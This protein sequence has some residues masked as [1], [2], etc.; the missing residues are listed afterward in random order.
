[1]YTFTS[2]KFTETVEMDDT[3]IPFGTTA[4]VTLDF[5]FSNIQVNGKGK[6][7]DVKHHWPFNNKRAREYE[8]ELLN[9]TGVME[10]NIGGLLFKEGQLIYLDMACVITHL[11]AVV[12]VKIDP[13]FRIYGSISIDEFNDLEKEIKRFKNTLDIDNDLLHEHDRLLKVTYKNRDSVLV[14]ILP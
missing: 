4:F 5:G 8:L 1:M 13:E 12:N 11:P 3:K 2:I 6:I 7:I 14:S 9:F 10:T